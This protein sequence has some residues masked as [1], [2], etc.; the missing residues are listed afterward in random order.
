MKARFS[1]N[2]RALHTSYGGW[3]KLN[4]DGKIV[5]PFA[6][7]DST[8]EDEEALIIKDLAEINRDIPCMHFLHV[9]RTERLTTPYNEARFRGL[10]SHIYYEEFTI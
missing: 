1:S 7:D 4:E 6:V 8:T 2:E 5:V 9:N 10:L 3:D